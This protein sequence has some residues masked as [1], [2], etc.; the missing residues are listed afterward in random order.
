M[1][2]A[3]MLRLNTMTSASAIEIILFFISLKLLFKSFYLL[4]LPAC[5]LRLVQ[6]PANYISPPDMQKDLC[7]HRRTCPVNVS[8][9]NILRNDFRK[10][11]LTNKRSAATLACKNCA[12]V[13]HTCQA[14]NC[15]HKNGHS[16]FR[17]THNSDTLY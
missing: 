11:G 9:F 1:A 8:V 2:L 7:V 12:H 6:H 17:K 16:P 13:Q 4:R 14:L 10:K 5:Y 15:T 3:E